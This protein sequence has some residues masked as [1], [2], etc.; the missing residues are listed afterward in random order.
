MSAEAIQQHKT[1]TQVNIPAKKETDSS[2]TLT[3]FIN[4]NDQ[5]SGQPLQDKGLRTTSNSSTA[6][7]TQAVV[8]P[9]IQA[10]NK[11]IKV[12]K[13]DARVLN[14]LECLNQR[15]CALHQ[16]GSVMASSVSVA[17]TFAFILDAYG[18]Q[19]QEELL[20]FLDL[21]DLSVEQVKKALVAVGQKIQLPESFKDG[22]ISHATGVFS[23]SSAVSSEGLKRLQQLE[24]DNINGKPR[25]GQIGD[26]YE[27]RS[28][29][30]IQ[31][32]DLKPE[33]FNIFNLLALN[34]KWQRRFQR[35]EEGD[36]TMK[37]TFS[38]GSTKNVPS[39]S[40]DPNE[41]RT[42]HDGSPVENKPLIIKGFEDKKNKFDFF[43]IP[44]LS[45]EGRSIRL[46]VI[47][48][49]DVQD[50][51]KVEQLITPENK[52]KWMANSKSHYIKILR[53]GQ[54]QIIMNL[55]L[56]S[57]LKKLGFT[58]DDASLDSSFDKQGIILKE[59][60]QSMS[61]QSDEI[62]TVV[63]IVQIIQGTPMG[64][65]DGKLTLDRSHILIV[66]DDDTE[67]LRLRV[68]SPNL[69]PDKHIM[70]QHQSSQD[71]R[72]YRQYSS[73]WWLRQIKYDEE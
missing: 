20:K 42:N 68:D 46:L 22:K 10:D 3:K 8:A 69:F 33:Q 62:G 72:I 24:I 50:L 5:S 35:D 56:L 70:S 39:M 49:D 37:F 26:W 47:I 43:E 31:K 44:Y 9:K 1:P 4:Q 54:I 65:G 64:L 27:Q 6:D 29:G 38:N 2:Q 48:P 60:N 63:T 16:G 11:E 59:M 55:D 7:K 58:L 28:E 19:K 61:F 34:L 36:G 17:R 23:R 13:A 67:L 12:S 14:A 41:T 15:L 21:S 66:Q 40:I 45:P 52:R 18:K 73:N 32:R 30:R 51:A 53:M 71:V 25:A 57:D